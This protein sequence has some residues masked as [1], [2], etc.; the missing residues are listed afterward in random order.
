MAHARQGVITKRKA[1]NK[2]KA[3]YKLKTKRTISQV[4][5]NGRLTNKYAFS[6]KI[7]KSNKYRY[8]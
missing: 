4:A 3:K 8:V 7:T 5:R 2:N 6:K 1:T